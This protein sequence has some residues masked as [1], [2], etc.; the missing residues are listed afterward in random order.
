MAR[1]IAEA[2]VR[3][4]ADRRGLGQSI[5]R[6]FRAAIKEA[7]GEGMFTDIERDADQSA[8]KTA[9]H[10]REALG[11]VTSLVGG[12]V[13]AMGSITKALLIGTAAVG[14]VAG[15]IQL[16]AAIGALAGAAVQAA[17]VLGLLPAIFAAFKASTAAIQLGLQGMSEAFSAIAADDA[18][19]FAEA[20]E[21]LSPAARQFARAVR[22]VKPAFD[23]M[24][25]DVQEELFRGLAD[26]VRPLA[27]TY[28]PI[29]SGAFQG[30]AR[31]A[32]QAARETA[33]FM[34]EAAQVQKVREFSD[35]LREAFGNIAGA[36]QPATSALLDLVNV[37]SNFLPGMTAALNTWAQ[38]FSA[39]ISDMAR[40]GELEAF[41]QNAINTMRDLGEIA[42]N[43]FGGIRNI[44]NGA[45]ASG[46]SMLDTIRMLT[47]QFQQFTGSFQGQ[48][49]I[50]GFFESIR[51]VVAALGPA[52]FELV[53]VIGRDL[54]PILADIAGIMGPILRP[55][56][57][58][59]GR[60]LQ[61]LR[62]VFVAVAEAVA[63][64]MEAL[65][66]FF[67]AL[68]EAITGAM[69]IIGP[70]IQDIGE[71][72]G[73]LFEAMVPLAPLFVQLLEAIL[74]I[75]PP[76]IDMVAELMPR[77]IEIIEALI[78][79][80]AAWIELWVEL[81][82]V[83]T[84]I[85]GFLLD[86]FIPVI[87]A[88]AA[89]FTFILE[90]IT[91]CVSGIKDII[92]IVFTAIGDF[93]SGFW[94]GVTGLFDSETTEI[95]DMVGG[96]FSNLWNSAKEGIANFAGSIGGGLDG[97]VQN[98]QNWIGGILD[99]IGGWVGDMFQAGKDMIVGLL[100]G[101][102][103]AAGQVI[104]WFKNLAGEAVKAVTSALGIFSPSRVFA[105]IGRNVG[106]GLIVGL[107]DITPAVASAAADM[108]GVTVDGFGNPLLSSGAVAAAAGVGGTG[109]VVNQTNVM[110][111]GADVKQFSDLVLGRTMG[112]YLS[113][114]ST[115]TVAR[116]GVQAGI[117]DQWVGV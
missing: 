78:P 113:G 106:A 48:Q 63:T 52:F 20:L 30:V 3:L 109:T 2:A 89:V 85:I 100:N 26:V 74:P 42:G 68:G 24:R 13:S 60:L 22:D 81:L 15:V 23:A 7:V 17:G 11:V 67:D 72:F 104:Q 14:A 87:E 19:A 69:P 84:D 40:S 33:A 97:I 55:I 93:F 82:P 110:Q 50:G 58:A 103:S 99:A 111:P 92:V 112:D 65:I 25:L 83:L 36:L 38:Q 62:P 96:W 41:F 28:I 95:E 8:K 79:L 35:N 80:I 66:P 32:N 39:R 4:V 107:R 6:E 46:A 71:A 49:A 73:R 18:T 114:A 115:L 9:G 108:A 90:V 43:V 34:L 56:F 5:R 21:D 105:D 29:M 88:V 77:F 47:E 61:A 59:F 70:M 98:F 51:R 16:G 76:I 91:F 37:G 45:A 57:E 44:I 117:N 102:K 1:V 75:I 101:L 31:Q 53:T 10:W 12:F 116:T 27:D 64:A 86:V 94:D 54:L